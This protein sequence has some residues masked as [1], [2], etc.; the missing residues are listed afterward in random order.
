MVQ[1]AW[2]T[3]WQFFMKLNTPLRFK[4]ASPL[5]R[6]YPN[7]IKAYIRAKTCTRMFIRAWFIMVNHWKP[8]RPS[9]GEWM[10]KLWYQMEN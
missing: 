1:P 7:E 9:P 10:E 2:K 6:I 3:G 5:L 8:P 4:P